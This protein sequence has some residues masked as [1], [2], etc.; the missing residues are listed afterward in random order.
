GTSVEAEGDLLVA[1]DTEVTE[2]LLLEGLARDLVSRIQS[3][4]KEAA[5]DVTDRIRVEVRDDAGPLVRRSLEA[6]GSLVRGETLAEGGIGFV[7]GD[8][9]GWSEFELPDGAGRVALRIARA[10]RTRA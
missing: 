9:E 5:L 6:Q 7:A 3:L 4:R 8:R 2:P 1:L 10:A